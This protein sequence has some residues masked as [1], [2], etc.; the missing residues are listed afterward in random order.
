MTV[1][2]L[3]PIPEIKHSHWHSL[4]WAAMSK[5]GIRA[6]ETSLCLKS[7][8]QLQC[9][10]GATVKLSLTWLMLSHGSSMAFGADNFANHKYQSFPLIF[11]ADGRRL[12]AAAL[13][14]QMLTDR[15]PLLNLLWLREK[16]LHLVQT[17]GKNSAPAHAPSPCTAPLKSA[18]HGNIQ[19]PRHRRFLCA[20]PP[21][22]CPSSWNHQ[23]HKERPA[24]TSVAL[25]L[26][27]K[28]PAIFDI[29][30]ISNYDL[31]I[32][33]GEASSGLGFLANIPIA[34]LLTEQFCIWVK[35][36]LCQKWDPNCTCPP[37]LITLQCTELTHKP[38]K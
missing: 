36:S 26:I 7:V 5:S 16:V 28:A 23:W 20:P 31:F 24:T 10:K 3:C 38:T 15:T 22:P 29:I 19:G 17:L 11:T 8:T 32:Q 12:S 9:L 18:L 6:S 34:F 27:G 13:F 30:V 14:R 1:A 25:V 37:L 35:P 4:Y 2:V 21:H 33:A